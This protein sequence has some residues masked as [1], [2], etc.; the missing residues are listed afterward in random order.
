VPAQPQSL[1]PIPH[2]TPLP[3]PHPLQGNRQ[4]CPFLPCLGAMH[5]AELVHGLSTDGL[6][7]TAFLGVLCF[8]VVP[9]FP[10][11][12]AFREAMLSHVC[13]SSWMYLSPRGNDFPRH[14]HFFP[15]HWICRFSWMYCI[16]LLRGAEN[17]LCF[18]LKPLFCGSQMHD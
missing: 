6:R 15:R 10:D 18:F 13:G 7:D 4:A 3:H 14:H 1:C 8:L 17:S 9:H 12:P 16:L 2:P 5:P 11:V